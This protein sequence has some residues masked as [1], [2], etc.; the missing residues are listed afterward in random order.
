MKNLMQYLDQ[1]W[2][3]INRLKDGHKMTPLTPGGSGSQRGMFNEPRGVAVNPSNG[4]L[5]VCDTENHRVQI[6]DVNCNF[7]KSIGCK[8]KN[9]VS[10]C[11]M[12][13]TTDKLLKWST[14][15]V[16]IILKPTIFTSGRVQGTYQLYL[17]PVGTTPG[18]RP[19]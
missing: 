4:D 15:S 1:I 14:K 17:R 7:V 10:H 3:K 8:G 9:K 16:V 13:K 5:A 19:L 6:F 11:V 12:E 18:L 2:T